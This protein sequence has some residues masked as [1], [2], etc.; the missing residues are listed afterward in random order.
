MKGLISMRIPLGSE[1]MTTVRLTTGGVCALKGLDIDASEDCKVCVTESL[2]LLR[3]AGYGEAAVDFSD[4]DGLMVA[5]EGAG[6]RKKASPAPEDEI[7]AALLEAL[8]ESVRM[9]K[10]EGAIFSVS[11]RF[12]L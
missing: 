8:A 3:H 10:K 12:A 7:S 5:I 11:F 2:L 6:R 9:E 1:L 4:D